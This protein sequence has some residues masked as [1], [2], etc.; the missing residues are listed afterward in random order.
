MMSSIKA[1]VPGYMRHTERYLPKRMDGWL[2]IATRP[3]SVPAI[4]DALLLRLPLFEPCLEPQQALIPYGADAVDPLL[5]FVERFRRQ[6]IALFSPFLMH[7]NQARSFKNREM[8]ENTLP[9][10][11][12]FLGELSR[13]L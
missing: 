11:W 7:G 2:S 9:R 12:I 4:S 3:A 5:K 10:N 13:R 6:E 8:F 1:G